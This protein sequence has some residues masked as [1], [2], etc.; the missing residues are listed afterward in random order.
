VQREQGAHGAERIAASG[1]DVIRRQADLDA[2]L[3]QFAELDDAKLRRPARLELGRGRVADAALLEDP[4]LLGRGQQRM[5]ELDVGAEQPGPLQLHDWA[6]A[7]RVHGNRQAECAG[8]IPVALYLL[9]RQHSAG[10]RS[11]RAADGQGAEVTRTDAEGEQIVLV[12][13]PVLFDARQAGEIHGRVV[14]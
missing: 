2:G 8:T 10:R 12:G 7:G 5:D 13:H 9:D 1:G 11:R 4:P 6:G 3:Q 14:G